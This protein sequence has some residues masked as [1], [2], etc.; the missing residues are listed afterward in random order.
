MKKFLY[1]FLGT[2]AGIWLSVLL[3]GLLIFLTVAALMD[4]VMSKPADFNSGSVLRIDLSGTMVDRAYS[5]SFQDA[6]RS[7]GEDRLSMADI[8][9]AIQKAKK[10]K[11]I[12][13]I[14]L[15][16][17]S[18]VDAGLAQCDEIIKALN[19][20]KASKKWI[21]A[22][23]D[24][25]SQADYF[26]ASA[27]DSVYVNPV[28]MVDVHGLGGSMF[29]F[30]DLL[31]KIGVEAQVVRVGTYKSAMEPFL[32][33][34]ISE[35]NREQTL[36]FLNRLWDSMR[37]VMAKGRKVEADSIDAWADRYE[38]AQPCSTYVAD[39][40]VNGLLYRRQLDDKVL[41][42]T[43]TKELQ[44]VD[45]QDYISADQLA[46]LN[47]D[48]DGT[49]VAVLYA[50]GDITE[51]GEG[52]IA[53]D[54]L[55]PE[56][57]KLAKDKTIAGLVLRV[58]SGG[59]SAFA[60]E[61]IWEALEQYKSETGNPFYV[62]MGDMAASGGYYISCGA[63]KIF[64]SPMTLT[65]SIGIF[66]VIPNAG[67]LLKDKLGV[68]TVTLTT[69]VGNFPDFFAPM[70]E[71]QR[72]AMQEYVDRGYELFVKRVAESR[73]MTTDEVN[74][75]AQGRVWAGTSALEAGLVDELGGLR[76]TLTAMAVEL[77]VKYEDLV[78]EQ[79]PLYAPQWWEPL[80]NMSD[81]EMYA[82][83]A[84]SLTTSPKIYGEA[85]KR[86]RSMYPLQCRA[87]YIYLR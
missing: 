60:S 72:A 67:K 22:Y 31:D 45:F 49:K 59:G 83:L 68:N 69:N 18:G 71:G 2:M 75:V 84:S 80:F 5:R 76:E 44:Y 48:K 86:I 78:I 87:N 23:A 34:D 41:K 7:G 12:A 46:G 38:F 11:K 30:K 54:R 10:D 57:L 50:Q 8:V 74:E 66:G 63:D 6:L 79:Y 25:Y 42:K 35:A 33:N 43:G 77:G 65:G 13:G 4:N 9:N 36:H 37:G 62:S 53:S 51:N 56:I 17:S 15:V 64:A 29:F 39:K 3:G 24:N 73:G 85:V 52:G 32:L 58:N 61:Q 20:F 26:I 21:W 14:L 16:C 40:V 28:G 19:D 55:V 82:A 70:N 1:S 47:A 27:A 81:S